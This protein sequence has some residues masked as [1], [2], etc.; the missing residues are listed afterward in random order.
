MASRLAPTI[1]PDTAFFWDGLKEHKL[2]I[3]R[4]AACGVLRHPPRPMCPRCNSL[5]WDAVDCWRFYND[6][7]DAERVFKTGKQALA[8][9]HLVS[10]S[11]RANEVAF[12]LRLIAYNTDLLFQRAA[13]QAAVAE[14]RPVLRLGLK[15]RQ[16]RLFGLAG[17][18][19]RVHDGWVLRLPK[20]R[21]VAD[22]WAFYA[23]RPMQL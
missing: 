20:S 7:G 14:Q 9:G 8:L 2:L 15:A 23:P 22:L 17:L 3:Q 21:R 18:L 5:D 1:T 13:E 10:Q 6:R 12:I 16:P 19:L 4:C 11:F